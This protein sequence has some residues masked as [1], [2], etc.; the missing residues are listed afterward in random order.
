MKYLATLFLF[1]AF[2]TLQAQQQH[3]FNEDF[4]YTAGDSLTNH[5]YLISSGG[6]T[7]AIL[8][9]SPGLTFTNYF[10]LGKAAGLTT[11]G[12][13]V[14][15]SFP[16][17]SGNSIYSSFLV[18]VS[19]AQATGDYFY[20]LSPKESQ[21][22]YFGRVFIKSSGAGF[23]FGISK[24]N[25]TAKYGTTVFNF[26]TTYLVGVK[27]TFDAAKDSNDVVN[28]Y[29]FSDGASLTTEPVTPEIADTAVTKADAK[30]LGFITLRQGTASNAPTL[31]IDGI[32]VD[33][34][35]NGLMEIVSG[36]AVYSIGTGNVPGELAHYATLKA[37][38]DALNAR[39][40]AWI[41]ADHMYYITSNLTESSNVNVGLNTNG[42]TITFKP[43][44][45]TT[46]SIKFTQ[47]A[48][49][50]GLSGCWVIGVK[51]LTTSST[52]N[53]GMSLNDSTENIII[54]GS[55]TD[56]GTT[57][58]L[59]VV[60]ASN[61]NGNENPFRIFGKSHNIT[62]KNTV[63]ATGQSVSY[64]VLLTPR[65]STKT[66]PD[67]GGNYVPRNIT[68]DNCDI[69]NTIGSAGQGIAIS[70][71]GTMTDFPTGIV[72]SNNKITARTR[73]I[74]L[75]GAGNTDIFGND[76][77]VN[78]TSSGLN[79]F[80]VYAFNIISSADTT[81]IYNNRMRLLQ[82]ANTTTGAFGIQGI[83]VETQGVYNIYNNTITGYTLPAGAQGIYYGIELSTG[84]VNGITANV[85][86]NTVY[87]GNTN[88]AGA[89]IT[90][91]AFYLN[92]TGASGTRV[93][94][95]KNNIF[96]TNVPNYTAYA[97]VVTTGNTGTLTSDNNLL[98]AA[99]ANG[100][101][102][103]YAGTADAT[104]A[105]WKT[106]SSQDA[107][108]ASGNPQFVSE[109]DLHING[110]AFPISAASNAGTPISGITTDMDGN[111]RDATHP[112]I[113]AFEF[114]V[115][116]SGITAVSIAEAS[117]ID[118]STLIPIH[119]ALVDTLSIS[120]VVT[121]PN[122]QGLSGN[123]SFCIQD[124]TGGIDVFQYG[125]STATN[126]VIGDSVFAIGT[127]Q[128][129]HGLIEFVPLTLDAAHFGL[130]THGAA[131]PKP[132]LLTAAEYAANAHGY[133]SQVVEIDSLFKA[134]GTWPGA[135][136]N[137]S[138]YLR[139]ADSTDTLQLFI[140][141]NTNLGNFKQPPY[142]INVVGV[143]SQYST[144]TPPN[145]GYEIIPRSIDDIGVLTIPSVPTIIGLN[146]AVSQRSDTL[147]LAWHPDT[148]YVKYVFQLS[149]DAAF[150]T[151]V[152]ND[153]TVTDTTKMVNGLEKLTK[154]FWRVN[155]YDAGGH[156]AFS[157]VD[158]FTT[159]ISA[160]DKPT[161]VSPT[162]TNVARKP[163]FV[164]HPAARAEKYNLQIATVSN[165]S[166]LV[167]NLMIT[168]PDTTVQIADTLA[169]NTTYYWKI[170]AVDTGGTTFSNVPH[171]V[172]GTLVL[173]DGAVNNLP[174]EFAL[175]QNY[176]NPFNPS[177][178]INFD[179][180]QDVNVQITVFNILGQR[181]AVLVDG[182]M[183]AGYHQVVFN[184]NRFASGAYIYEMRAGDKVFK[185]K[186]LLLK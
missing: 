130:V 37:A 159:I 138:V 140:N 185:E 64:A 102:G 17:D 178:T 126:F 123:T 56:G 94:N 66:A 158:S 88:T 53:Y 13:D 19:A 114:A 115:G 50:S 82:T 108:S 132:K 78:Q 57:R 97:T 155:A 58:D 44:T 89:T 5:G 154:Y 15:Q 21:T 1:A 177:T 135:A 176:P 23:V 71:S 46:D 109:S 96:A 172:T 124:T 34:T 105:D 181:V 173:V 139:T 171:F 153:S 122:L 75:N 6:T 112:D 152:V 55:N 63:V 127:V 51:N 169:A 16:A 120:G 163:I 62:V 100:K 98:Y 142:P 10:T 70:A 166:T 36:T 93:A 137:A 31:T 143:V 32:R 179:L 81:N 99:G 146:G 38:C 12:Q 35:W 148:F 80:G 111:L 9:V 18:N 150:S 92:M 157:L 40:G 24:N 118:S 86:Y 161:L 28:V 104:L 11:T 79:S 101:V 136:T 65:Y 20:A 149:K 170:G 52:Y 156:S 39:S 145:N 14:Y 180:P 160:P 49:N 85:Y 147:V 182:V 7:N 83:A 8:T 27:Y 103:N 164:W 72:F 151:L 30:N 91:T 116:S 47:T 84:T 162:G 25:E 26:N 74:F 68:I 175:H 61:V 43:Y 59:I 77:Y 144:H 22:N 168:A 121:T 141:K 87:M 106:A 45:G 174:T 90:Q 117:K 110:T 41:T 129:Y 134:S 33:T 128:Q 4:D 125:T 3:L 95:V 184:A 48:D 107:H 2:S 183:R 131:L 69:T 54:D 167:V 76:I 29:V 60:T 113:G 42:H 133:M 186:M 73:G 67:T 119:S 165:F